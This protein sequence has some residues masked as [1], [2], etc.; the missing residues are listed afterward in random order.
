M[1]KIKK[2]FF[3]HSIKGVRFISYKIPRNFFLLI[4]KKKLILEKE[5]EK[6]PVLF[7]KLVIELNQSA[8]ICQESYTFL[9]H[10]LINNID[11]ITKKKWIKI[12][13]LH[14]SL[15]LSED[16]HLG[17]LKDRHYFSLTDFKYNKEKLIIKRDLLLLKYYNLFKL[18]KK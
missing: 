17:L 5:N 8:I 7:N 6:I 3:D 4:Q 2:I 9:Y 1:L 14:D 11:I 13:E 18:N 15:I 12:K 16:L 10:Y